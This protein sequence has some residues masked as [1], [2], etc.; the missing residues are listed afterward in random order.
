MSEIRKY[1]I[2]D[3][4]DNSDD[5]EYDTLQEAIEACVT[6]E[7]L[8]VVERVYTYDDSELVWTSTGDNVWPP[9]A[10]GDRMEVHS[11]HDNDS[12]QHWSV[13]GDLRASDGDANYDYTEPIVTAARAAGLSISADPETSCSYFYCPDEATAR[14]VVDIINQIVPVMWTRTKS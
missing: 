11:P 7:P 13:I 3:A 4:N 10:A 6:D 8:A 1:V 14:Q 2:V 9:S 5:A 12:T